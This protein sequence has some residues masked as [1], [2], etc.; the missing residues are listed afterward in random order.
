MPT[1]IWVFSPN[2]PC[3]ALCSNRIRCS[4][5]FPCWWFA[6]NTSSPTEGQH[7]QARYHGFGCLNRMLSAPKQQVEHT[8][9]DVSKW[10]EEPPVGSP[11]P[12][13]WVDGLCVPHEVWRGHS[14]TSEA[15]EDGDRTLSCLRLQAPDASIILKSDG[16]PLKQWSSPAFFVYG[17]SKRWLLYES[18]RAFFFF[19]FT[20]LL[21]KVK[22]RIKWECVQT[23]EFDPCFIHSKSH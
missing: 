18:P 23:P 1:T 20:V 9:L 13:S 6:L 3:V 7:S 15:I 11:A 5:H 14:L 22:A 17:V 10:S 12:R 21:L 19:G 2:N 8:H 4:Q 16:L